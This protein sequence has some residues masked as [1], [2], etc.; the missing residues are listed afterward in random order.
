MLS[1][2]SMSL[3]HLERNVGG[4]GEIE[5]RIYG[6]GQLGGIALPG[7]PLVT[8]HMSRSLINLIAGS[9]QNCRFQVQVSRP[10]ACTS[11]LMINI[12]SSYARL[13]P[14]RDLLS[15][16][17]ETPSRRNGLS[18]IG[19]VVFKYSSPT[20]HS[21]L[22]RVDQRQAPIIARPIGCAIR[23]FCP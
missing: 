23:R 18:L 15:V 9:S 14:L 11:S 19:L 21:L 22:E 2:D 20:L 10:I 17:S 1:M 4:S 13:C 12:L 3:W 6:A 8:C 16:L 5:R 7:R